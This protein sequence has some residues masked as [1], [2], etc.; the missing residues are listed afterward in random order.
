MKKFLCVFITA[1]FCSSAMIANTRVLTEKTPSDDPNKNHYYN[2][3]YYD[4]LVVNYKGCKWRVGGS[5]IWNEPSTR[6]PVRRRSVG[7][8]Y[9]VY[10]LASYDTPTYTIHVVNTTTPSGSVC[11]L[12][13]KTIR[14]PE[15]GEKVSRWERSRDGGLTWTNI[16]C[17]D[18]QYTESNPTAG[19]AMYRVLGTDGTYSDVVTITYV[20]AVPSTIQT[21]PGATNTKMVDDTIIFTVDVVDNGYTYQWKKDGTDIP[22][23]VNYRHKVSAMKTRHAGVYTC[24][25]S[26]GCNAVT[27]SSAKLIVNKCPQV[28]DFPE[29]PVH[30]YSSGL[31]YTLPKATNKGLTITYQSMNTSVATISGNILTIKAPGTTVISASQVGNDDYLEA[32]PVSRTLTVNKRSQVITFGEL[33]IK[34]YED[35]PFTLP[36]KTDEG[37]TISY[38]STNTAVAT[39][40]G[41]TVTIH[42]PG[43]TDIIASQAGDATHYAAAEVSQTLIVNKAAQEISFGSLASKTYGDKPFELNKVTNKNLTITYTSSDASLASIENNVVTI[44]KPGTVTITANQAGNAYYLAAEPVAQTLTINKANQSINFPALESRAYDSGDFELPKLTDKGETISYTS[45]KS[46]VATITDNIVHITGAGTTEI[47]A[48]Q[49]GNEYYNVA[50]SVSQSLTITKATQTINFPELPACVF[51]QDSLTLE[52]T[53]NSGLE[54]EYESSDYSVATVN[55]NKLAIVGAGTCYITASVA[56]NKNYYTATPIE[57][58]LVV[59]KA[60]SVLTFEAFEGDYTYG[61]APVALTAYGSSDKIVFTSSNP[62]KLLIAGT[63]AIIQGAG[64]YTITAT[65]EEDANHLPVSVSQEITINKAALTVTANDA[66]RKYGEDNPIFTYSFKGFVNGDSKSDLTANVEISTNAIINSPVGAYE[67]VATATADDN[68]NITCKKGVLTIEKAPLAISTQGT[69]EYGENNPDFVFSYEGFKNNENSFVLT[70]QPTAYTTAKKSSPAGTYPIYISGASATNYEIAYEEGALVV[71]KAPLTITALNATRKRTQANPKFELSFDGFKLEDTQAD[72]EKLPT[73]QCLADAN[74][75]AGTYPIVL[76]DDGFDTNYT[77]TLVN[78]VLTVEKLTYTITALSQDETMGE[79]FGSGTYAE[80]ETIQIYAEPKS[81]YHFVKWTDE[82]TEAT[83]TITVFEDATYTA[84]FAVNQYTI[85]WKQDN[86]TLIDQTVVEY[87]QVPSHVDP[88][89]PATAEFT[90]SFAGWSPQVVA[91][92]SDATYTATYNSTR[93]KYT[94]TWKQDDGTVIDQTVVEYGKVPTHA[95]PSKLATAEF[96][97]T[98]AGWTPSVV[99]VTG[100]ATYT[101]TYSSALRKYTINFKDDDGTTLC[102]D[103]WEYGATPYCEEPTKADDEQYTYTFAG[104]TPEI[105]AVVA[106]ATYTATYTATAKPEGVEDIDAGPAPRKVMIDGVFYILRGDH[107]Y[108]LTGQEVR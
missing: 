17:T 68:Y 3:E 56:G 51:G 108:T 5:S 43:T 58:T 63:N 62:S 94:I 67:I 76:L 31:T 87:G 69:R 97:Y 49:D 77:Y 78:G 15:K 53:V 9:S 33:P 54:I 66:S 45:S 85:T 21:L 23:A 25:V 71:T 73:I 80:D 57:R 48:S 96:V 39:V 16:A 42:K 93:N 34:T 24:V 75:P 82:N 70:A 28:I 65:I 105:V 90:Y 36:Q 8:T 7:E 61:D 59:N 11:S 55:G 19:T 13:S 22:N 104:W 47:T 50:P 103:A 98:F 29:I 92:T 100:D 95:N 81:H 27:S 18:Y 4:T 46:D 86:G 64:H 99:A 88:S 41:N 10:F 2:V 83:R 102:S 35:L 101:A 14:I 38:T 1:L 106:E 37:L 84:V 32:T 91:A 72:L 40:S 60:Q 52:A 20:D 26:N 30:T 12:T 44:N 74:S 6:S 79:A 107:T 89:K